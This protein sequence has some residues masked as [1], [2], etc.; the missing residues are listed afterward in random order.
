MRRSLILLIFFLSGVSALIYQVAWVR[1]ATL[2]FGVSV[3]AYSVVLAAFMGGVALGSYVMGPRADW[4]KAP[5]RVYAL[6]QGGIAV[7][8][9]IAFWALTGLMPLYGVLAQSLPPGSPWITLVRALFSILVLAPPTLLMG[10]TLPVM[11]RALARHAGRVGNDVGQLYAADTLGAAIGCAAAG[12]WLLRTIGTQ[13]TI[14]VAVGLNVLAA[15]LSGVLARRAAPLPATAAS[16]A[17]DRPT[18]TGRPAETMS[19]MQTWTPRVVLW[20]YTLSGFAA[21]GYEVVWARI[22]AIFT[23]DAIF[24][25]SIMLTTFLTGLAV[26]GWL[27][28][29]WIRRHRAASLAD[30]VILQVAIGLTALLTLY[31]FAALPALTL[32]DVLGAYSVANVMYYEFLVGF[33]TLFLPTVLLGMLFP[34][35]VSLYT[36]ETVHRVGR[37][38]GRLNA[39]NTAGAVIGALAT[40][41]VLIP[42]AGLQASGAILAILNLLIG[43]VASWF[44]RAQGVATHWAPQAGVVLGIVLVLLL[45]ERYYL[46]FRAGPSEHMVFYAEGIET[47]V[48]V[49]EVPEEEFKVSFVNGRIEVPTDAVSMSAFRLLGHLPALLRPDAERALMLSFGNGI[50]TGALDTHGIQHIDAVDLAAEQFAAAG[51]Y[52]RENYNVLRSP[53]VHAYVEDGRN[54]LLQTPHT[55]DIITTDA[56]HPSNTSSWALFTREFYASVDERLAA[57]GVFMQWVPVHSL[58]EADYKMILRTFQDAFPHATLWYTGGSHTLLL[59]TPHRL[60]EERLTAAINAAR[61]NAIVADDL[62]NVVALRGYLAMDEDA[63]REFVGSGPLATDNNAYFLPHAADTQAILRTMPTAAE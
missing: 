63:L 43:L 39:F 33:A 20:A 42:L 4:V 26:G 51:V 56:T 40:G 49:F 57:D 17:A 15:L 47:T 61:S 31:L 25:F 23:L 19:G 7:L 24:S 45:P 22:L 54:F 44:A 16:S 48:A 13:E 32:E 38:V 62:G 5:L 35:A 29:A 27:G 60:T 30:F 50:S 46:G 59:A 36:Q 55:Y 8:G 2:V 34:I 1:Q 21:L 37:Q 18:S 12:L 6:L 9:A 52:W 53:R 10:A 41:F 14:Y 28:V 3:Y 58:T 11:A